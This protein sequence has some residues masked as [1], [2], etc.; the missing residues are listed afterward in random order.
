MGLFSRKVEIKQKTKK[1][2]FKEIVNQLMWLTIGAIIVAFALESFMLPHKIFDGGVIGVAMMLNCITHIQ[3]GILIF[4]INLPFMLLAFKKLGIRFVL[5][6]FYAVSALAIATNFIH[7][8]IA[9]KDSLLAPVFGGIILG[10]GV[11]LILKN[12]AS[13]DGTEIMSINLSQ[14]FSFMTVGEFLMGFNLF[15]YMAAG[16]M[17]GWDKAMYSIMTYF[18]ASKTIDVV[19]EG[20]NSSKSVRIVSDY[21]REVGASIMKELDVSVTYI[22]SKGG[23]SGSDKVLT[24][25]VVSR[26]EM[27][28]LK[29]LVRDIDP[30]AFIVVENVHEVEGVRVKKK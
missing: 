2:L 11:G 7:W 16:V 23:Y 25:C 9:T 28:K 10:A 14:K 1:E 18:I 8:E 13:L 21:H 5:Q 3:L 15:I 24:F 20:F 6:T 29:R 17:F 27:A 12:N 26:L 19:M 4:V 22:K 30:K